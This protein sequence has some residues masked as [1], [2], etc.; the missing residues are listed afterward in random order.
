[1]HLKE[2]ERGEGGI[3]CIHVAQDRDK[4]QAGAKAVINLRFP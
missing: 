1:M 4:W 3:D 2:I